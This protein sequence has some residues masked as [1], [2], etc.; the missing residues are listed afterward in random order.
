MTV[1]CG[2]SEAEL[3]IDYVQGR[4]DRIHAIRQIQIVSTVRS[5]QLQL[6][7]LLHG[8]SPAIVI[9]AEVDDVIYKSLAP[10]LSLKLASCRCD[11][12][13]A[14][15]CLQSGAIDRFNRA[16]AAF[17]FSLS[18]LIRDWSPQLE[19]LTKF[20]EFSAIITL[21]FSLRTYH[22]G[23]SYRLAEA[24]PERMTIVLG[25]HRS[26]TSAL[27]GML[28]MA[29]LQAPSDVLGASPGNP[30]GYWESRS[31]V[32]LTDRFLSQIGH[33][34]SKLFLLPSRWL[35]HE[36]VEVWVGDY[37]RGVSHCF[38]SGEHVLLKDPRLC[39]VLSALLPAFTAG[40]CANDYLLIL[41]SPVEVI[42]S[43]TTIHPVSALDA[44]CLWIASVLHSE[45]I[46]RFLPR[47]IITF[48]QLLDSPVEILKTC[49]SMWSL[50][51]SVHSDHPAAHFIEKSLYR[52]KINE[53][54]PVIVSQSP[55]IESLLGF[56]EKLFRLFGSQESASSHRV[57]DRMHEIWLCKLADL[58]FA[59]VD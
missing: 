23:F 56:A 16:V 45:R 44:L 35:E 53:I 38:R 6:V 15:S 50:D 18:A 7:D 2:P 12:I 43:L 1:V 51:C 21:Q 49:K 20:L 47:R 28:Q 36:E 41:R 11:L 25:M 57:L 54:R 24:L 52:Q 19:G 10:R 32:A 48:R 26:G 29:G 42:A 46:T 59:T 40:A 9:A 3:I 5:R 39:L 30:L 13:R 27:T 8:L 14:L 17:C 33:S 58:D 22:L 4:W 55:E 34:W 31:L 37:L